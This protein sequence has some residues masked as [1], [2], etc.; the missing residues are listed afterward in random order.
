MKKFKVLH[1]IDHLGAG[2]AQQIV[3]GIHSNLNGNT[4]DI[5]VFPLRECKKEQVSFLT[6]HIKIFIAKYS[7]TP[8]FYILKLI[9]HNRITILHCHLLRSQIFGYIIKR[10]FK[11][12]II[13]VFHE[14]GQILRINILQKILIAIAKE[15]VDIFIAV[16]DAV[17][18]M[19]C[20]SF[21]INKKK[22]FRLYNFIDLKKYKRLSKK[23]VI[24]KKSKLGIPLN[25]YIIGFAGRLV[26]LKGWKDYVQAANILS[27]KD[28]SFFFLIAGDGK[29][30][31]QM[32]YLIEKNENILYIGNLDNMIPFY[33]LVDCIVIP[34]HRESFSLVAIE[35]Q[36]MG[37]P[38]VASNTDGLN[39]VVSL[40]N[41]NIFKKHNIH[42]LADKIEHVRN[43]KNDSR[44]KVLRGKK[45]IL[46]YD[47]T[48]YMDSL[49]SIY[50]SSLLV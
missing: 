27:K 21:K 14:H 44:K 7:L 17:K 23:K 15:Q 19:I 37:I 20:E 40:E 12:N 9:N 8:L 10:F 2:G 30:K 50:K 1:I 38:I 26:S 39:E 41:A 36:S 24:E 46:K 22:V 4:H 11:P 25:V 6:K 13:L 28:K 43:N 31:E 34:S 29:Q 35:A 18:T 3:K 16:S 5:Y 33:S 45:N 32:K 47:V 49:L 42:D 48:Q